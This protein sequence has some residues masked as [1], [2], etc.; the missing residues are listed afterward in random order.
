MQ[1]DSAMHS[2]FRARDAVLPFLSDAFADL[3]AKLAAARL[4]FKLPLKD[5]PDV[6]YIYFAAILFVALIVELVVRGERAQEDT[7]KVVSERVD[8]VAEHM[9][10]DR[11]I[12]V[13]RNEIDG[14]E[15]ELMEDVEETVELVEASV[16]TVASLAEFDP[17]EVGFK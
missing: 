5:H 3:R 2:I 16:G 6:A 4:D 1:F 15:D 13:L 14:I 9:E 12:D 7:A 11:E 17:D 10:I 8:S